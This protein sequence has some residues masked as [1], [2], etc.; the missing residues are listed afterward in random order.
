VARDPNSIRFIIIGGI[1]ARGRKVP[2]IIN[3]RGCNPDRWRSNKNPEMAT[4][5]STPG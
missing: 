2:P 1:I 3:R 5:V 4:V